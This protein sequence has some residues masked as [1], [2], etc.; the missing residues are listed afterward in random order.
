MR[1]NKHEVWAGASHTLGRRSFASARRSRDGAR[2][3]VPG[4]WIL[5]I[6][7]AGQLAIRGGRCALG[8][9]G[10]LVLRIVCV[11][12]GVAMVYTDE[13]RLRRLPRTNDWRAQLT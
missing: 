9:L 2:V 4:A 10:R 5:A 6:D 13:H 1:R 12:E 8:D 11:R 7:A 3:L